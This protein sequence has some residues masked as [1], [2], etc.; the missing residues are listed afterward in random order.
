MLSPL[1]ALA[2]LVGIPQSVTGSVSIRER[3]ALS[4]AAEV[5]VALDRFDSKGQTNVS[6]VV[7]KLNGAQSPIPYIL[8]YLSSSAD[9]GAEFAVRAEI[10]IEGKRRFQSGPSVQVIA[11]NRFKADLMLT[12]V[13][14][15]P[16]FKLTDISW[17]LWTLEGRPVEDVQRRPTLVFQSDGKIAGFGGVN[18]FGGSYLLNQGIQIDPG[19]MTLM[20]GPEPL[21]RIEGDFVRLLP[22][23][24]RFTIEEGQLHLWRGEREIAMFRKVL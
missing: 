5:R 8:P 14:L 22:L 11:N 19:A 21:M 16:L 15:E 9:R 6:E 1:L 7:L 18:R 12:A 17:Q 23:A 4:S 13:P 10:W 24:N 2:I 3:I 20:A